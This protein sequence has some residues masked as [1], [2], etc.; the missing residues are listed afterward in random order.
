MFLLGKMV[1]VT[2]TIPKGTGLK[3]LST[4][5]KSLIED[6]EKDKSTTL[7]VFAYYGTNRAVL[8]AT[9]ERRRHHN[10]IHLRLIP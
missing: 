10:A 7:P 8:D 3:Q 4:F 9:I 1:K 2:A 6:F 5:L